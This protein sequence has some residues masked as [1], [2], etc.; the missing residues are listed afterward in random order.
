MHQIT[1]GQIR[2]DIKK[3]RVLTREFKWNRTAQGFSTA[4]SLKKYIGR[5]KESL[6]SQQEIDL[7]A[8]IAVKDTVKIK[9]IGEGPIFRD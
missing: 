1:K 7:A 4:D 9:L 5:F 2:F 6:K 3:G 8:N